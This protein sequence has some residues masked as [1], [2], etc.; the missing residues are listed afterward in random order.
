MQQKGEEILETERWKKQPFFILQKSKFKID[1]NSRILVR[2]LTLSIHT[3]LYSCW[4]PCCRN[5]RWH[6]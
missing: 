2:A 5:V 1:N 6:F 4:M 3:I